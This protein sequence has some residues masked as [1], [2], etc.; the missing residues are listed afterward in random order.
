MRTRKP[1][2]GT[3]R[4]YAHTRQLWTSLRLSDAF[5]LGTCLGLGTY[6]V[7]RCQTGSTQVGTPLTLG[8]RLCP[9]VRSRIAPSC[10]FAP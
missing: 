4:M 7:C 8:S 6:N 1:E 5:L 9:R 2:S 3:V 10:A